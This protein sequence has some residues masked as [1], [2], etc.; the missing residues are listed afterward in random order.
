MTGVL[1]LI[2]SQVWNHPVKVPHEVIRRAADTNVWP[3]PYQPLSI[4]AREM[5]RFLLMETP[6]AIL[7][8]V[9]CT[10]WCEWCGCAMIA[11]IG[12]FTCRFMYWRPQG[13]RGLAGVIT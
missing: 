1:S 12:L 13:R 2:V 9:L 7:F 4:Q 11:L 5:V 3:V 8:G 10:E 6:A